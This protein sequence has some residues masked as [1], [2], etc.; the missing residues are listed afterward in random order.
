VPTVELNELERIYQAQSPRWRVSFVKSLQIHFN[1]NETPIFWDRN[2][3]NEHVRRMMPTCIDN[4]NLE[5][6]EWTFSNE[7]DLKLLKQAYENEELA[8]LI[9]NSRSPLHERVKKALP[10]YKKASIRALIDRCWTEWPERFRQFSLSY[11]VAVLP[12]SD[13]DAVYC[14]F[15]NRH[16]AIEWWEVNRNERYFER[17]EGWSC[18][19]IPLIPHSRYILNRPDVE[20]SVPRGALIEVLSE[21][22]FAL[23]YTGNV[24][25]YDMQVTYHQ[26]FLSIMD[27]VS[28][29]TYELKNKIDADLTMEDYGKGLSWGYKW[30]VTQAVDAVFGGIGKLFH[31]LKS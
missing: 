30:L 20:N 21:D 28:A 26:K 31:F 18:Y 25:G 5:T 9:K 2:Q 6:F 3:T 4:F 14:G 8:N 17:Y 10:Y 11:S 27:D 13:V 12:A 1:I 22:T 7:F 29:G 24:V 19:R 15:Q 16:D 23:T